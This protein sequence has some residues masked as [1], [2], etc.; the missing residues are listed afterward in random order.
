MA[1][2][3]R[4]VPDK[5]MFAQKM[6]NHLWKNYSVDGRIRVV[7][8]WSSI[9]ELQ[10]DKAKLST[11]Y[12]VGVNIGAYSRNEFR[13]KLGDEVVDDPSMDERT[14]TGQAATLDSVIIGTP[15]EANP[16][17]NNLLPPKQ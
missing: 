13:K 3:N 16:N 10:E 7:P 9:P 6:T 12:A 4:I 14:V 8:D 15:P 17:D 2:T 5:N 11:T 1:Y